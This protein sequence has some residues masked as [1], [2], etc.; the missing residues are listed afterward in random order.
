MTKDNDLEQR[1]RLK[2]ITKDE[3]MR[4]IRVLRPETLERLKQMKKKGLFPHQSSS[5]RRQSST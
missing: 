2:P 4:Q 5:K 3:R 1:F